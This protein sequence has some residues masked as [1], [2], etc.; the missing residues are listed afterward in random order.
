M[1]SLQNTCLYR[2]WQTGSHHSHYILGLFLFYGY[3]CVYTSC[4]PGVWGRS[5]ED[6]GSLEE[7][8]MMVVR[9]HVGSEIENSCSLHQ[10]QVFLI[11]EHLSLAPI[12]RILV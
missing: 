4:G 9:Y 2:D 3:A 10:Q 6:L 5:R 7:E 12:F 8:L 1:S 11:K